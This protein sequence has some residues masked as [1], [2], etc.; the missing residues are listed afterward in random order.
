MKKKLFA[1]GAAAVLAFGL[2][3]CG[4]DDSNV[5][6]LEYSGTASNKDFN[7]QLFEDF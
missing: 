4:E 5:I 2:A 3:S 6:K 1:L 7:M